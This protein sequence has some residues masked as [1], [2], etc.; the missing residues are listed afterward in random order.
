MRMR[1]F[2]LAMACMFSLCVVGAKAQDDPPV[3]EDTAEFVLGQD[4]DEITVDGETYTA[5]KLAAST[6]KYIIIRGTPR[7]W[8]PRPG[9]I[10]I[11]CVAP[12]N[13]ICVIIR[14]RPVLSS[15]SGQ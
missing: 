4:A 14:L 5:D 12:Y 13:R 6:S 11:R 10:V 3:A 15:D 2:F 1:I 8:R 7:I 9:V